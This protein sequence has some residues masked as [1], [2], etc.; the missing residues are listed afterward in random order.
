MT[1]KTTTAGILSNLNTKYSGKTI[2]DS[3]GEEMI[4]EVVAS[5]LCGGNVRSLTEELTRK[6]LGVS[7]AILFAAFLHSQNETERFVERIPEL[8]KVEM[9]RKPTEERQFLQ[10][11]IGLTQKGIQN[12][13]RDEGGALV[14]YLNAYEGA[15]KEAVA[16][17]TKDYGE[18]DGVAKL[19][20]IEAKMDWPFILSLFAA[21][22]SQTL[23][24]RGSEKSMYGKLFERLVL[25]SLLT[26]LGF[27]LT[28]TRDISSS[29]GVFWLSE[30]GNKRECDATL[31]YQPGLGANFDIGFIGRGN[32]EISLDKVSRFER[33]AE[34]AE[35]RYAMMTIIVV[36]KIGSKSKIKELANNIGGHIVQM[37][38]THWVKDVCNILHT[39][40]GFQHPI[41]DLPDAELSAFIQTSMQSVSL[42][43]FL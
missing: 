31:L 28:D 33:Q 21:I 23:T 42:R 37:S 26:I 13:L 9:E 30:K 1:K 29:E 39:Q 6:R 11:C 5:I 38:M 16:E 43:N 17:V 15:L 10:W 40:W 36:D 7:N 32:T 25:G 18:F 19:S 8:A 2:I 3:L 22:G 24:I 27:E 4:R 20:G 41:N 14:E 34:H 12:I 35:E